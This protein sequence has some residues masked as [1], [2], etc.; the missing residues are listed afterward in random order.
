MK[1]FT[2]GRVKFGDEKSL[3]GSEIFARMN[4]AHP[5]TGIVPANVA[6]SDFRNTYSITGFCGIDPYVA[7]VFILIRD[8]TNDAKAF[9]KTFEQLIATQWL[10]RGDVLVLDNASIHGFGCNRDF[11]E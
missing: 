6:T 4:R 10:D 2:P 1:H 11:E 3:K 5:V 7:P 9:S 8:G